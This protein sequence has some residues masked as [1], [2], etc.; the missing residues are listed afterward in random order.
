MKI[1]V[2][3]AGGFIGGW[4]CEELA[5]RQDIELVPCLRHWYSAVRL[6]RRGLNVIQID[7]EDVTNNLAVIADAD[8]VVNA[9]M[10]S[11]DREP[12]LALRLYSA[13]AAAGVRKFIQ[14]SSIAVYGDRIG[15][16]TEDMSPSPTN[17]YGRGKTEMESRLLKAASQSETQLFILRPTLVYGPF[18]ETWTV[19][20]ARRIA[21]GRWHSFG[22]AAAGNCNLVHCRDVA[23]SAVLAA[24]SQATEKSYVLNINGPE[25]VTWNEYINRFGSALGVSDRTKINPL[26][27]SLASAATNLVRKTGSWAKQRGFHR[28][29][30]QGMPAVVD[31]AQSATDLYPTPDEIRLWRQKVRYSWDRASQVIGFN[32]S[33]S[34]DEGL[35]QSVEWCRIHGVVC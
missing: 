1:V 27:F 10:P 2:F 18:S 20:Y 4:L 32:P 14:F 17:A 26:S 24:L 25:V 5:G 9:S 11:P 22:W 7:L 28:S 29:L 15:D 31:R 6:A 23:N 3:G 33:I 19:R 13:C 21:N 30:K 34:L 35:R 16:I 8:V 12:E